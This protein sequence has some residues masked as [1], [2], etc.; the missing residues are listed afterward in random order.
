MPDI[1]VVFKSMPPMVC[2]LLALAI[3][4]KVFLLWWNS[5]KQKGARGE[6]RVAQRLRDGL[7]EEYRIMNDVYLPLPDGTTTQIDH[8]VV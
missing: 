4:L 8:I 6:R 3:A 7:P 5:P 2:V 1:G